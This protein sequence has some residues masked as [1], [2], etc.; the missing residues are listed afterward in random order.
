MDKAAAV[1]NFNNAILSG[2]INSD[3]FKLGYIIEG[4]GYPAL[5]IGSS[6]YYQKSFSEEIKKH[7]RFIFLDHRG[8]V[9]PP[10]ENL[11]IDSYSLSAL[12]EDI[13]FARKQLQ[14]EE[15]LIIG[16]SGHAFM[17]LEYAKKYPAFI[18]GVVMIGVTPDYSA[19]THRAAQEFFD[20][21]ASIERKKEFEKNMG[22]LGEIIAAAPEKRFVSYCLASAPKSWYNFQY[23]AAHLW[24]GVYTN[25]QMID[26]V[27]GQ[28]FRDIDITDGLGRFDKPVFLALGKYDFQTGPTFLWDRVKKHFKNIT[29]NIFEHSA[30]SPQQEEAPRFTEA[31]LRWY[32][33]IV[34][35]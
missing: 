27:W 7:F 11:S 4:E 28:V 21:T 17:A 18:K 16:H 23:D 20:Q 35:K 25:M 3:G 29:I 19:A 10:H 8:F 33:A 31:L 34:F 15:M 30:H 1:K 32:N 2:T 13:E 9:A 24:D 6:S 22:A 26:H 5:V 14:I 12:I